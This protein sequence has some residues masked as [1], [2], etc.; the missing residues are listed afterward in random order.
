LLL[1]YF[2]IYL[3]ELDSFLDN[4]RLA[5]DFLCLPVLPT[6]LYEALLEMTVLPLLPKS[7]LLEVMV[8]ILGVLER[9]GDQSGGGMY[10]LSIE[11]LSYRCVVDSKSF[12]LDFILGIE[13]LA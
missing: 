12:L 3:E 1:I 8:F 10:S 9:I 7:Y 13:F 11:G 4:N 2:P 6:F 5:L